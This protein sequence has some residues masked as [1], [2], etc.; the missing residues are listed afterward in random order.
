MKPSIRPHSAVL[1]VGLFAWIAFN[2]S[3]AVAPRPPEQ[4]MEEVREQYDGPVIYGRDLDV[5]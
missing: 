4:M 5:F 3:A 1:F 2:A